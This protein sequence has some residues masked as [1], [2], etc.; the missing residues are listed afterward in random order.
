ML[1]L[2]V[3]L[4]KEC[5][6]STWGFDSPISKELN[7]IFRALDLK[8]YIHAHRLVPVA[9]EVTKAKEHTP[10]SFCFLN[11][12]NSSKSP[13]QS[14]GIKQPSDTASMHFRKIEERCQ[15]RLGGSVS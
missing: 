2:L 4:I 15:G 13:E 10:E 14:C 8:D 12:Q 11:G 1:V 6:A 7:N 3:P 9:W 5:C